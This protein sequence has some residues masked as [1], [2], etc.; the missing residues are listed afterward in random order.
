M[1]AT[2]TPGTKKTQQLKSSPESLI[3]RALLA[4]D[5]THDFDIWLNMYATTWSRL[6][7]V[8]R[9]LLSNERRAKNYLRQI[10]LPGWDETRGRMA[11]S[12]NLMT[13]ESTMREMYHKHKNGLYETHKEYIRDCHRVFEFLHICYP[14]EWFQEEMKEIM[15]KCKSF[16]V[17]LYHIMWRYDEGAKPFEIRKLFDLHVREYCFVRFY[18]LLQTHKYSLDFLAAY[19]IGVLDKLD[20]IKLNNAYWNHETCH[21]RLREICSYYAQVIKFDK[22]FVK[23]QF[24]HTIVRFL[25]KKD[26]CPQELHELYVIQKIFSGASFFIPLHRVIADLVSYEKMFRIKIRI[27]TD[28]LIKIYGELV[29]HD[30]P[31]AKVNL[32]QMILIESADQ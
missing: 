10:H 18:S 16:D 28:H 25:R 11:G 26:P 20:L 4:Y 19:C 15:D 13:P 21:G 29:F 22:R 5:G 7:I 17:L 30:F 27:A 24:T 31:W 32:R 8:E 3:S 6:G 1:Y 2:S 14:Y 9:V 12:I 23:L